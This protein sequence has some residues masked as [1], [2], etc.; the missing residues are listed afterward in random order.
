MGWCRGG[1]WGGAQVMFGVL[2]RC[3][4]G[5]CRSEVWGG[6]EVSSGVQR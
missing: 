3:G 2:R 5:W 4:L 6:A 1:V